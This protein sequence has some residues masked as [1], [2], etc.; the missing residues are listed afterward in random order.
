MVFSFRCVICLDGLDGR[1]NIPY[2]CA[3]KYHDEC[4]EDYR[5]SGMVC[6]LCRQPERAHMRQKRIRDM[7]ASYRER[8]SIR[9]AIE[10]EE[11]ND[12]V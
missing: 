7:M 3:H 12:G 2:L 11:L 5:K 9:N 4:I 6:P 10:G 8:H 1:V